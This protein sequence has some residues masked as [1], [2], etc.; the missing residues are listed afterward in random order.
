MSAPL[1]ELLLRR[2]RL[3]AEAVPVVERLIKAWDQGHTALQ[4]DPAEARLF[5]GSAAISRGGEPK[6]LVLQPGR[7]LQ[8]WRLYQ[9]EQRIHAKLLGLAQVPA[10]M[11][12]SPVAKAL[13]QLWPS[14]ADAQRQAAELG[15]TKRLALITGGPGT[16]KTYTAA[17]LLALLSLQTPGFRF[18]LAAP[19]G[20][21]AQRLG[22]SVAKASHQ[23]PEALAGQA[24]VLEQAGRQACTLHR[25]LAWRPGADKCGYNAARTL[26]FDGVL[27]DEASMLDVMLWDALLQAL[28]PRT[29]LIVLGDHRQLESVEPGR[30]LGGLVEAADV[31]GALQG[32]H[33]ELRTNHRFAEHPGIGQLAQAIRDHQVEPLAVKSDE[34]EL[35]GSGD[36]DAA[37][38]RV[39]P[40][41]L[42]L[43]TATGPGPALTALGHLRVLCA[44]NDGPWG[45]DGLNQRIERR[46]AAEGLARHAS[47]VLVRVNDAHSGLFNG[48][49]G[50][51]L[52]WESGFAACFGDADQPRVLPLTHLPDHG[53]AWAMTVHRSQGSEY[54][55]VLL[56]LPPEP[57]EL[58]GPELLYTAVTRAKAWVGIVADPAVLEAGVKAR[59][60]R[61]TGLAI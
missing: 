2:Y 56:V 10:E 41:V 11:P 14:A 45:V 27:V 42:A 30:V 25:L 34:V 12:T 18:A 22:E 19:T 52:P 8:S 37:L 6:P 58:V 3:K 61:L 21:A 38:G 36:L 35:F 17:R 32:C 26:P 9:A 4:L 23:L 28:G 60:R 7:L 53:V 1:L 54:Q 50:V 47:P 33:V 46:L 13:V 16:G 20:K 48:D 29:R 57:H 44:L 5:E 49:L 51:I 59:P 31:P 24:G 43:A 55:R 15:L 40:E 39:W